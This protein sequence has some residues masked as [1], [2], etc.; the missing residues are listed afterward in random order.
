MEKSKLLCWGELGAAAIE[1]SLAILQK[2]KNRTTI[3]SSNS[4]PGYMPPKDGKWG[5][6]KISVHSSVQQYY[7]QW[8]NGGSNRGREM[9]SIY[10]EECHPALNREETLTHVTISLEE[11]ILLCENMLLKPDKYYVIPLRWGTQRQKVVAR[12][13]ARNEKFNG[14]KISVLQD[15]KI[16]EDG[17]W[18]WLPQNMNIL[19]TTELY[20]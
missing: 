17:R 3:W 16:C 8:L 9:W 18:W 1:N 15:K 10:T 7:S 6:G 14:C 2:L 4:I 19:R 20:A 13:W 12:G 11:D 5:Q